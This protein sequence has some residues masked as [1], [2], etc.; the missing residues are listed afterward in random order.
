MVNRS[1]I[2]VRGKDSTA[3][4]QNLATTNMKLF[5][6]NEGQAALYTGFLNVK[7]KLQYDAFIA[8]PKLAA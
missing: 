4:L 1:V 7:G 5:S 2:S 6:Q 8:K 3:I